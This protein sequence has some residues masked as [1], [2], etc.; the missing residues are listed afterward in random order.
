MKRILFFACLAALLICCKKK[1]PPPAGVISTDIFPNSVGYTW[2]YQL[3][4]NPTQTLVVNVVGDGTLPGGYN[5]AIWQYTY[6]TFTDSLWVRVSS[7]GDTVI[8]YGKTCQGCVPATFAE[9]RRFEFPLIINKTWY[10]AATGLTA[11]VVAETTITV[12]LGQ[13]TSTLEV[14]QTGPATTDTLW[15][16]EHVGFVKITQNESGFA[17]NGTWLLNSYNL[18]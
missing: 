11:Q 15:L 10:A 5:A 1:T 17:G 4:G 7:N 16:E 3:S 2:T 9:V 14:A 13:Y 6:P 18:K 12:P 8:F